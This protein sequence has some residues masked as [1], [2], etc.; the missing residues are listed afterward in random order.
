[1]A[2]PPPRPFQIVCQGRKADVPVSDSCVPITF[3]TREP[4][5]VCTPAWMFEVTSDNEGMFR[6]SQG[7][8]AFAQ[9]GVVIACDQPTVFQVFRNRDGTFLVAIPDAELIWGV[10]PDNT[11][12]IMDAQQAITP[13]KLFSFQ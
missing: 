13:N 1:M 3:G 6:N 11:L 12:G 4:D 7:L 5:F 9:G 10:K 2:T 8:Y